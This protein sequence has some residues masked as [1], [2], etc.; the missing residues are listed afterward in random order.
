M[1]LMRVKTN[2]VELFTIAENFAVFQDIAVELDQEFRGGAWTTLGFAEARKMFA[3]GV[4][5]ECEQVIVA[6]DDADEGRLNEIS[7]IVTTAKQAGLMV[8]LL[9]K[10]ISPAAMHKL[11]RSGADDFLPYPTPEGA[12]GECME[13]LRLGGAEQAKTGSPKRK[14]KG[15]VLP[16]YGV[17]GGVGATTF[18]VN[19]AWELAIATRKTG[20][21]VCILD[22]NFQYG[23]VAT[24]LD[25]PRLEAIYELISDTTALDDTGLAQALT[26]FNKRMAV[27]TA[28]MDALPYDI[29]GPEDVRRLLELAAGAYDFVIIDMPQALTHWTENVLHAAESFFVLME[30]DMRSAQNMLRFIR[31]LKAEELPLEKL[32]VVLNRSPKFTDITGKGRVKRMAESLGVEFRIM[33]PDGGTSV[34]NACDQGSPLAEQAK[35]NALRKEIKRVA[36]SVLESV[37]SQTAAIA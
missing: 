31:T 19:L 17:A 14:R 7:A 28:P 1:Q 16:V 29:I 23:S 27:L 32:E 11:L 34:V 37:D 36:A 10:D 22:F 33:L 30:I 21:R 8:I 4:P 35:S 9:A 15:V 6:V 2:P 12:L 20:K 13:R 25:L 26:S 5:A 18:A 3:S 24:Y